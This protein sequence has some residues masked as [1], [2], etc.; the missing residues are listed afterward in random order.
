MRDWA[1]TE[2]ALYWL[3]GVCLPDDGDPIED[4]ESLIRRD[5]KRLSFNSAAVGH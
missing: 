2:V 5:P 3:S 1:E 4:E